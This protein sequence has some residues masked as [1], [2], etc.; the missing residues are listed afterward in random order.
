[1]SSRFPQPAGTVYVNV[2]EKSLVVYVPASIGPRQSLP[3]P[4][5]GF[6]QTFAAAEGLTAEEDAGE[7]ACGVGDINGV[8]GYDEA[9]DADEPVDPQAATSN[10]QRTNA[11]ASLIATD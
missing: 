6:G 3:I 8:A 11:L 5:S 2:G 4:I 1:M 9:L 7:G 10:A